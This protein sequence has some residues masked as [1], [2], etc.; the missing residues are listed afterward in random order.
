M[1]SQSLPTAIVTGAGSGIGRA[2]A[3]RLASDGYA[4]VVADRAA[5]PADETVRQLQENGHKARAVVLDITDPVA[6]QS[7]I[8]GA[9]DLQV[10]VNNAGIFNVIPF[11]TLTADD[12]RRMYEVNLIA[13]FTLCQQAARVL[14]EGGRII[15]LASRA[16]FGARHYA[17]YVASKAGVAGFTKALALELAGRQITVNA[18]APGVIETDMLLERPDGLAEMRAQ[19]P[20]GKLGKPEHIAH[21]AAFFASPLAEYVTGQVLIV[22]GGRSVGGTAAF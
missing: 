10:L 18:I 19:Q 15:N 22:D 12:F 2:I 17:H 3:H 8:E 20:T 1:S 5:A 6:T 7:L 21:A 9:A 4:I 13:M 11:E 16:A 14:P